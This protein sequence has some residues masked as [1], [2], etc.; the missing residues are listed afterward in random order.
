MLR[1]M[2]DVLN[3]SPWL[4]ERLWLRLTLKQK[5][6]INTLSL[7]QMKLLHQKD[8]LS[9]YDLFSIVNTNYFKDYELF[10]ETHWKKVLTYAKH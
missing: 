8:R 9:Y 1:I 7:I 10:K 4:F 6:T 2:N 3:K 5:D